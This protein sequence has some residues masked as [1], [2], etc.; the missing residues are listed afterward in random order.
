MS[1]WLHGRHSRSIVAPRVSLVLEEKKEK[2][3]KDHIGM[4]VGYLN[5]EP[6]S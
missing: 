4:G 6:D 3:K 5:S 2:K 1:C